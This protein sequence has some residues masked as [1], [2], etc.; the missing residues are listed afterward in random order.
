MGEA[1]KSKALMSPHL[2]DWS[3]ESDWSEPARLLDQGELL[4]G[5]PVKSNAN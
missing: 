3:D 4:A 2:S 1:L 5:T